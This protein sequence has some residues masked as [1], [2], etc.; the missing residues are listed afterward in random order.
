MMRFVLPVLL[1]GLALS[2]CDGATGASHPPRDR[3]GP[4][5][6]VPVETGPVEPTNVSVVWR[7]VEHSASGAFF[8]S[9]LTIENRG[10]GVLDA[11][12]WH[13]YFSFVRRVLED[14]EGDESAV[15]DLA[16]QGI[17]IAK[18]DVAASGDYHVLEPLPDFAP[19]GPGERRSFD[20]LAEAWA[21]LRTDAPAGFHIAFDEGGEEATALAVP[22][23]AVIDASDPAQTTRFAGDVMPVE[24]PALRHAENPPHQ[25]LGLADR[26]LPAPRQVEPGPGQV[27]LRGDVAIEHPDALAS[28]A[29]YLAAALTGVLD[30]SFSLREATGDHRA[31]AIR[32]GLDPDIDID[33]D[34]RPDAEAYV[35]DVERHRVTIRGSDPAGVLHGIQTLRQLVPQDA[36]LAAAGPARRRGEISL[37]EVHIADMPGF[38]YRGMHLDVARHFQ[39]VETVKKLLDLMAHHK[40]NKF[41]IHLTDDEGWRLEIP[42]IPELTEYGG[43][44]GH[45]VAEIDMLH[46]GLGSGDD[47]APGDGIAAKPASEADANG[48][49]EPA[50]QGFE[51]AT[52]NFVG[53]GHGYY[54]TEEFEEILAY[55]AE[56]HIDVIPEVDV[57]GHARAAVKAMERR[58][59]AYRDSDPVK[60]SEFRLID[61]DDTSVHTSVQGYTDN[62]ANPCL[63]STYAFLS[64]VLAAIEARY[65][66][67]PGAQLVAVHGGGDEL[68]GLAANT[69][70]Q[71]SPVC[72]QNPDT[73]GLTDPELYNLFF[74]RWHQIITAT[75]AEMTGW[76]DIIHN[77]LALDGFVPMPWS[78]V[79]GWGREDDAYRY[80]NQGH[81]VILSHATNL[82]MDLAYSKDPD[83]PGYYWAN[84]VDVKKTFEYT[85]FDIFANATHDRMGAPIDPSAWDDKE[86]LTGAG[87][88]NVLGMHGLLWGENLK[89]PELL[90]YF[91][92]P[93]LLGVAER[94]WNPD[95]AQPPTAPESWARFAN[96]LGQHVLPR[97]AMYRAV[98]LRGELPPAV[99][100]NY[101][102]PLP[103][104]VIVGG[105][106]H[107]SV[108][109]PGLTI[110]YSTDGGQTWAAYSEPVALAGPVALRTRSPDGRSSRIT[111]I[112]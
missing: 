67:V 22:A 69:W 85:P 90:E 8:R 40:L 101:R 48:G 36:N 68:P 103:G 97:L 2:G 51:T 20:I 61:P 74:T 79:W 111:R 83:E 53:Q 109:F 75:G 4:A 13:L 27:I 57:P 21:I 112:D 32:L 12:G 82:Y 98:D 25:E 47:L 59:L 58:Y 24:T 77:G 45:D 108:Q 18:G 81:R 76:D 7:P 17:R 10:P 14:G 102:I 46:S 3:S 94:A 37:P 1:T 42:G 66:A 52:V 31:G 5:G 93:K 30:A 89:T 54:S 92:F 62:F 100:V 50:Y 107:A 110:E 88:A 55:A 28:E 87:R 80:A 86:R 44:R 72:Q 99:G 70:W 23:Q 39:S 105:R 26:L 78:N 60:A 104:A 64:A 91:A 56:R 65:D 84:F 34:G 71:G 29:A 63:E 6:P 96:R 106:L 33:C 73:A 35:L 43:R 41:H 16:G 9:E 15:Q 38:A 11:A 49:I 19:L 95:P